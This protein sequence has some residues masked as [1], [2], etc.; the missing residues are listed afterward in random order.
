MN[1]ELLQQALDAILH[2][3]SHT[4][5]NQGYNAFL[6]DKSIEALEAELASQALDKK[7]DNARELGLD[8]E[9]PGT[10]TDNADDIGRL[11]KVALRGRTHD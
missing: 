11:I 7:A 1:R 8:Y 6:V 2:L 9:P 10:E 3:C 5:A 4:R